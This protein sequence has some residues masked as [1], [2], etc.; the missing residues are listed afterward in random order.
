MRKIFIIFMVLGFLCLS[1][2]ED[3]QLDSGHGELTLLLFESL[4][5]DVEYCG[6]LYTNIV[7]TEYVCTVVQTGNLELVTNEV[8]DFL[9]RE[10]T[11]L[12]TWS[13]IGDMIYA[14]D[15]ESKLG[16]FSIEVVPND[17]ES[18]AIV[19]FTPHVSKIPS[20]DEVNIFA[21]ARGEGD[22]DILTVLA[23]GANPN[24]IDE[25]GQTPLMYAVEHGEPF[26]IR[27]LIDAGAD[28]NAQSLAGWTPLMYAARAEG[29]LLTVE[30]LIGYGADI[31]LTNEDNLTAF[32]IA[33]QAGNMDYRSILEP[34]RL[35]S[36]SAKPKADTTPT[37]LQ[38]IE[39][40]TSIELDIEPF[41]YSDA[42][43]ESFEASSF[44]KVYVCMLQMT[45]YL[46][47]QTTQKVY[48]LDALP[49]Y[50]VSV[51]LGKF[52]FVG[53]TVEP[54]YGRTAFTFYPELAE[55]LLGDASDR[56][57]FEYCELDAPSNL[58]STASLEL[59][60]VIN[61]HAIFIGCAT[62]IDVSGNPFYIYSMGNSP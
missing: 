11:A 9:E 44:C 6:Q 60:L 12:S 49:K 28:I 48:K 29:N 24:A 55:L 57:L 56:T 59:E 51:M 52:K 27:Y 26:T 50:D 7:G 42:G 31:T 15:Y 25:Y 1:F 62:G 3:M 33:G 10:L 18:W 17:S 34:E 37:E 13:F 21:A 47:N 20:K 16:I 2:G 40:E 54:Y 4:G 58:D 36:Q 19:G 8:D 46:D 30:T 38:E 14:K 41:L 45:N 39:L 5:T 43:F 61:G 53:V 22:F 23:A 35:S 32:D